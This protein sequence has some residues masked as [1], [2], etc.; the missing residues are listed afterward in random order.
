M[1][2][3]ASP[4][5]FAIKWGIFLGLVEVIIHLIFYLMGKPVTSITSWV[6][7]VMLIAFFILGIQNFRDKQQ[8]GYITWQ[9][10][11]VIA[12]VMGLTGAIIY[13]I[14]YTI[15][16]S[17]DHQT[18]VSASIEEAEQAIEKVKKLVTDEKTLEKLDEGLDQG[19]EKIRTM[20]PIKFG[21]NQ[22]TKSL[23]AIIPIA[24][25]VPIFLKKRDPA[26]VI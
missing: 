13:A 9:R 18:F 12:L 7:F 25:L 11:F 1:E 3:Q 6:Y 20:S 19:I 26:T 8:G 24:L 22:F 4:Y 17:M 21:L 5:T 23:T 15:M 2:T 16:V 14:Y 10:G